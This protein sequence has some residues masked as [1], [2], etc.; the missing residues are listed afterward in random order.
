MKKL[1]NCLYINKQE[2]YVHKERETLVIKQGGDKLMQ[3]PIHSLQHIFCFGNVLVSPFVLGFCGE[4][5]VGLSFFSVYGKFLGR[6]QGQQNGNILLRKAQYKQTETP[7]FLAQTF[8]AAKVANSRAVLQRH[9]RNHGVDENVTRA[10]KVL[11]QSLESIRFQ[12]D[13][14][15]IRGLE[16]NAAASYF[17]VIQTL[18]TN[19]DK[20]FRFSGRNRRPPRDAVNAM[21][22]FAYSLISS[23][24]SS[25]LQGVGLDPQAGFLHTDR[26][27]R[28]SLSQ[29]VLE[30]FRA[31]W[32]DRF[33]LSL[34]NR[35]Q[36]N[37][38][39]FDVQAGG[40][41]IMKEQTRKDFLTAWQD[42]K[43]EE[44]THPYLD[45]KIPI[46]LLPHVQS[47]LLARY[48]R[49]DIERYPPFLMR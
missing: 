34:V 39:G 32:A 30:E 42:K 19:K 45:E 36:I 8:V 3:L 10:V 35:K 48:L 25:A 4:N 40:A 27:G 49:G 13:V 31:Y 22:S 1:Q 20:A 24:I 41:V 5:N 38:K 33:V 9:N 17:S 28:D 18:I 21:M 14:N 11:G 43:Q 47:L 29:D 15:V 6:L 46:G 2:T 7:H 23:E 16:G 44:I 37:S 26:P 12:Q